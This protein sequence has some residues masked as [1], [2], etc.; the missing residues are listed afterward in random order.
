M[1]DPLADLIGAAQGEVLEWK[2]ATKEIAA[3]NLEL[4]LAA[5]LESLTGIARSDLRP[6]WLAIMDDLSE[7]A[8]SFY[9]SSIHQNA[10]TLAIFEQATPFRHLDGAN[11]GSRPSK[12]GALQGVDDI[13]AIPWN[14]GWLQSRLGLPGWFGLGAAVASW[15]EAHPDGLQQLREMAEFFPAFG[16]LLGDA[17]LGLVQS[18]L[19]IGRRYL[20][21]LSDGASKDRF[22]AL[23]EEEF[24][25]TRQ[26]I[27]Q[28][29]QMPELL[30]DRPVVTGSVKR[31]SGRIDL[32]NLCQVELMRR[33]REGTIGEA[34]ARAF[35]AALTATIQGLSQGLRNSG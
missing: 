26:A 14:F 15:L 5:G 28:I 2:Y 22:L 6:D 11:A 8:F 18:D 34:D 27:L 21:L 1:K 17:T 30:S 20:D 31:R 9:R 33:E 19:T 16:A 3:R 24:A 32:L 35:R 10:E 13:R 29:T 12:R 4:A 7:R 23:V 25:R